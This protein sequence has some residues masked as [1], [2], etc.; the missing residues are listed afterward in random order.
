MNRD[1]RWWGV[2]P[3]PLSRQY[4]ADSNLRKQERYS[5]LS[6]VDYVSGVDIHHHQNEC[7]DHVNFLMCRHYK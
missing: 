5:R 1:C 3:H 4:L 6:V 2:L 7:R